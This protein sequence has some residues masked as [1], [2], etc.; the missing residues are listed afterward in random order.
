MMIRLQP[1]QV[2]ENW[3]LVRP[4]IVE[5]LPPSLRVSADGISNILYSLL[6]EDAQ[7]WV[8]YRE[9]GD[10]RPKAIIVTTIMIDHVAGVKYL[11]IY[12]MYALERMS[13]Q[14]YIKGLDTLRQYAG[15]C[16]CKE[17][18]AY[19]EDDQFVRLLQQVG[20]VKVT[21]LVRL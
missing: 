1:E 6:S 17:I 4:M 5:T 7:F 2:K 11:L 10:G 15:A 9:E 18:I 16:D 3:N 8:Y 14:D 19:V 13:N 12:S 21:N 20:G